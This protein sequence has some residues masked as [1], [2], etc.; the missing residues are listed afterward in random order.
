MGVINFLPFILVFPLP[1][2][3]KRK[4]INKNL[5][6]GRAIVSPG[7]PFYPDENL[8]FSPAAIF[9]FTSFAKKKL[10]NET[11]LFILS[12]TMCNFS[13]RFDITQ[14]TDSSSEATFAIVRRGI[15]YAY[16]S[17][18]WSGAKNAP[19]KKVLEKFNMRGTTIK[20][21]LLLQFS[22]YNIDFLRGNR[23]LVFSLCK[24]VRS[25]PVVR[26]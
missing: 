17:I 2:C 26:P 10:R 3:Q 15:I 18:L 9:P 24:F 21:W 5:I 23:L 19:R 16:I 8:R 4:K 25:A 11:P 22:L 20:S 1:P 6:S 14:I 7:L 13:I 12:I